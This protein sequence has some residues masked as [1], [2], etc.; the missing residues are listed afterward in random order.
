MATEIKRVLVA[1]KVHA[2]GVRMLRDRADVVVDLVEAVTTEAYLPFLPQADAVLLRTQPMTAAD[3]A[4]ATKLQIV[5][6]HG[7]GY[8]AVDVA[9]LNG[10]NIP[11]TIV[12][13]VNSRT[14]AEH[15]LMLML[16]AAR[17]TV[18][19]HFAS[20][21]GNWNERNRFDSVE[22]DGKSL[23]VLGFGR[24]G[25]RVAELGKAFGMSVTAFDP[26]VTQQQMAEFGVQHAPDMT[27]A[28]A[29]AD[30]ISVHLPGGNGPLIGAQELALMKSSAIIVNA[31]RGGIIDELALDTAL[32]NRS[33]RAAAL[34]VL[35]QEPPAAD[36][37]LLSNPHITITPHNAG[38]TE[39]CAMRMSIAAA[40]NILDAF[41]GK[42][43]RRLVVNADKI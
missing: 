22:L 25:R 35:V 18:A 17:R 34:D 8:D 41:D 12:G 15:T 30:Y 43:D 38:L 16:T 4:T 42:L 33:L 24:I 10:R 5:S 7:V 40:Q 19:H 3:I 13:D 39:E 37:P 21:T 11:L 29:A 36:Y 32:R 23:L 6:R 9:A 31:A 26:Y 20:T 28:F 14:V 27:A 1:G 2:A